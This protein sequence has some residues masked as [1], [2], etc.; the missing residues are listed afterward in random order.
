MADKMEKLNLNLCACRL[1]Y[2]SSSMKKFD[3]NK[4]EGVRHVN[5]IRALVMTGN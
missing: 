2:T 1:K 4:E 3:A 5:M